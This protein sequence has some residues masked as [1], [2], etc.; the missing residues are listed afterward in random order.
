MY[1]IKWSVDEVPAGDPPNM[2]YWVAWNPEKKCYSSPRFDTR[3]E[4]YQFIVEKGLEYGSYAVEKDEV[5]LS[6]VTWSSWENVKRRVKS[7]QTV[8]DLGRTVKLFLENV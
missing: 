6:E 2:E 1:R 3:N 8:F 4:A 5:P 7:S